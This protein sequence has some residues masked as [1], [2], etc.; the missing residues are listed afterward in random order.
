MKIYVLIPLYNTKFTKIKE[1]EYR[2]RR[3]TLTPDYSMRFGVRNEYY[4]DLAYKE[5][6]ISG[7]RGASYEDGKGSWYYCAFDPVNVIKKRE[8]K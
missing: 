1:R 2:I 3:S 5:Q 7:Q 8:I 4:V 6:T